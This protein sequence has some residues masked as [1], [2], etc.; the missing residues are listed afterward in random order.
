M[1]EYESEL[2]KLVDQ[3]NRS[4]TNGKSSEK[5][6]LDQLL[7]R[8]FRHPAQHPARLGRIADQQVDFRG[9]VVARVEVEL[10]RQGAVGLDGYVS[11]DHV[12]R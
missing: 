10:S 2:S 9:P 12:G 5:R 1:A 4:V 8:H 7:E 3:L 6:S 11:V